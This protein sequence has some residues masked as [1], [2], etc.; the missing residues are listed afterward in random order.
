MTSFNEL[1]LLDAKIRSKQMN[2]KKVANFRHKITLTHTKFAREIPK[3][4]EH[5]CWM[6]FFDLPKRRSEMTSS[7]TQVYVIHFNNYNIIT[8]RF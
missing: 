7:L 8:V 6:R 1:D 2:N 3:T 4:N 5:R